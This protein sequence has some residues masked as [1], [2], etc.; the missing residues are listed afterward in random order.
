MALALQWSQCLDGDPA[1]GGGIHSPPCDGSI[2]IVSGINL[3][4]KFNRMDSYERVHA[5][6]RFF[7]LR[8]WILSKAL[9]AVG[10]VQ[11]GS[12]QSSAMQGA[13]RKKLFKPAIQS[14]LK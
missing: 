11:A 1:P 5:V 13:D 8:L 2:P 4:P 10:N 14:E 7:L 9:R 6:R 3:I 12:E